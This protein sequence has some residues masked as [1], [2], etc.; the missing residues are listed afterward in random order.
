MIFNP[1]NL[2]HLSDF[3]RAFALCPT[4]YINASY[5]RSRVSFGQLTSFV[6]SFLA[7]TKAEVLFLLTYHSLYVCC[8]WVIFASFHTFFFLRL[9]KIH[10]SF[11]ILKFVA[12]RKFHNYSLPS[13]KTHPSF[14]SKPHWA[15]KDWS[16][17]SIMYLLGRKK[18]SK[19]HLQ[20][21]AKNRWLIC[22]LV[23][24]QYFPRQV[25]QKWHCEIC[26][27][28]APP[29]LRTSYDMEYKWG[30]AKYLQPFSSELVTTRQHFFCAQMI[31]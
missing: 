4:I 20:L 14:K 21:E 18:L 6:L 27:K 23:T 9:L 22:C 17:V 2:L 29:A 26:D 1:L 19:F 28:M 31:V 13:F 8:N 10:S 15:H 30:G 24:I 16:R 11:P 3:S 25:S 7:L 12:H 5:L